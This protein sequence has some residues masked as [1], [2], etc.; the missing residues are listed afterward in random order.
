MTSQQKEA[1]RLN[2]MKQKAGTVT[3]ANYSAGKKAWDIANNPLT[4]FGYAA[5]GERLPNNFAAG[6]RNTLDNVVDIVNPASY[7]DSGINAVKSA[8]SAGKNIVKGELKKAGSDLADAGIN[9]LS[10][11]PG[12]IIGGKA[13]KKGLSAMKGEFT[14]AATKAPIK[15]AKEVAASTVASSPA[16]P[17]T[18]K[19]AVELGLDLPKAP[20]APKGPKVGKSKTELIKTYDAQFDAEGY[21]HKPF[22]KYNTKMYDDQKVIFG[23]IKEAEKGADDRWVA[24][25]KKN[26]NAKLNFAASEKD[27]SFVQRNTGAMQESEDFIK[28]HD[29]KNPNV[30]YT[31]AEQVATNAF[32]DSNYNADINNRYYN[33]KKIGNIKSKR[34]FSKEVAPHL[35]EAVKKTKLKSDEVLQSGMHDWEVKNVYRG[36]KRVKD[37]INFSDLEPGDIWK[38]GSFVSTTIND[39]VSQS[40]GNIQNKIRAPKGQSVLFTNATEVGMYPTEREVVLPSKL[41]FQVTHKRHGMDPGGRE[42]YNYSHKIMNPYKVTGAIAGGSMMFQGNKKK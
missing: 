7:I 25:A 10:A 33:P 5:R 1:R 17:M 9:A 21:S 32:T 6:K 41:R 19:K 31:K 37:K 42:Y 3:K 23:R 24:K 40:F 27:E 4:A 8:V 12:A 16:A 15:T 14:K 34:F 18:H 28:K 30:Q 36:G 26:H 22:Y 29:L 2:E 38:P 39:R 13:A 11:T 20:K 35:E